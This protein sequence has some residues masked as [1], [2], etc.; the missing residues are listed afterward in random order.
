MKAQIGKTLGP[1]GGEGRLCKRSRSVGRY[2][3][4]GHVVLA[5]HDVKV[6]EEDKDEIVVGSDEAGP[7]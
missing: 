5:A 4:N 2:D 1:S 3:G 7:S 6:G